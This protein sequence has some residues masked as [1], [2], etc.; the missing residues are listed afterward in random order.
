MICIT[1]RALAAETIALLNPLSCQ[2]IAV[3]SDPGT[4]WLAAIEAISP[5]LS[6]PGTGFGEACGAS[7]AETGPLLAGALART[8]EPVGSFSGWPISSIAS[9]FRPFIAAIW[10]TGRRLRDARAASVSPGRTM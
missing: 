2:A 10:A 8:G 6:R 4:P 5:A 3:A 7:A 9:G 1:P